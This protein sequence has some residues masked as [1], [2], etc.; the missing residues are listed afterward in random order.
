MRAFQRRLIGAL[1]QDLKRLFSIARNRLHP[2]FVACFG[3]FFGLMIPPAA[4]RS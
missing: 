4:I 2:R 1:A 3:V